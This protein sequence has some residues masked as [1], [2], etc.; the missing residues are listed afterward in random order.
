MSDIQKLIK[1]IAI[2]LA[3][4]IVITILCILFNLVS[5]LFPNSENNTKNF[6]EEY[7]NISKIEIDSDFSKIIIQKGDKFSVDGNNL[8]TSFTSTL[9]NGILKIEETSNKFWR[10]KYNG[11]VTITI[12]DTMLKSLDILHGA[13]SLIINGVSID[14]FELEQGAGKVL[15]SDVTFLNTIIE[16]GTGEIVIKSST[17]NNLDLDMGVGK[18]SLE[19]YLEGKNTIDCGIGSLDINLLGNQEEYQ[20]I[21]NKGIGAITIDGIKQSDGSIFGT[22]Y[23]TIKLDGGIGSI[24]VNFK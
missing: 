17:L 10:K 2:L 12:N 8:T 20:I 19:A 23:N 15:I 7:Q 1:Y 14:K 22:G 9:N 13:G 18:V 4:F 21:V 24:D 11:V 3:G 16:G 5:S 6:Y